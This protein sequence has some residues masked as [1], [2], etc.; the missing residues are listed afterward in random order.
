MIK[1]F[2][3]YFLDLA[4]MEMNSTIRLSGFHSQQSEFSGCKPSIGALSAPRVKTPNSQ[5]FIVVM[6]RDGEFPGFTHWHICVAFESL[7]TSHSVLSPSKIALI[8]NSHADGPLR[9]H[10]GGSKDLL[11]PHIV[12]LRGLQSHSSQKAALILSLALSV[13]ISKLLMMEHIL[14]QTRHQ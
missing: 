2:Y 11:P 4:A 9:G 3:P 10:H 7:L 14:R 13:P 6:A 12:P 1:D 8:P 5:C